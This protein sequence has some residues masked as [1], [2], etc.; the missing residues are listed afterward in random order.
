M[1]NIPWCPEGELPDETAVL[2]QRQAIADGQRALLGRLAA[3]NVTEVTTYQFIP[4]LAMAVDGPALKAVRSDPVVASI[5]PDVRA[6]QH[7][8]LSSKFA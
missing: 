6:I 4:S 3:H 1:L 7:E 2:A 5:Q 8:D